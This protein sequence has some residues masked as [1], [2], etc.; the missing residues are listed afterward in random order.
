L[1][2]ASGAK[3]IFVGPEGIRAGWRLVIFAAIVALFRLALRL[4]RGDIP[5]LTALE[6]RPVFVTRTISFLAFAAAAAIMARIEKKPWDSYG[7]PLRRALGLEPLV[8]ALWGFGGVSVVML[9]LYATGCYAIDGLALHGGDILKFGASWIGAFVALALFEEFSLRGY[10]L[11]T[12]ASGMGFWPAA[13]LLSVVFVVAHMANPGETTMGL[14]GV[15][16]AGMF[17]CFVLFRTG[18]LWCAVAMHAAWDWG[19]SFFYSVADS[20]M[21]A[22]GHLFDAR[23]EGPSWLA[24]GTAGPE[25][26]VVCT[27]LQIL[28]FPAFYFYTRRRSVRAELAPMKP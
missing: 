6:P 7:L 4:V 8:G 19:L 10:P 26:S 24:G 2:D 12:L 18:D 22:T 25:A 9:V 28:W 11:R 3:R 5:R 23:L 13:T 14:V 17:F 16:L 21:P 1:T 20:A 15:F 27:A